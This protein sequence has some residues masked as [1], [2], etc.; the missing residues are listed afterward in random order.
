MKVALGALRAAGGEMDLN[1]IKAAEG[2]TIMAALKRLE[3][4]E[5][6]AFG[7]RENRS[8]AEFESLPRQKHAFTPNDQQQKPGCDQKWR[9]RYI[10]AAWCYRRRKN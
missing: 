7:I 6:V 3:K 8:G 9:Q 1:D 5:M 2:P 4:K 10:S